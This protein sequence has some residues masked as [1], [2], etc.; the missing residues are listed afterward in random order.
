MGLCGNLRFW[1][2]NGLCLNNREYVH[3]YDELTQQ[4]ERVYGSSLHP[5]HASC[6]VWNG[7]AY[8]HCCHLNEKRIAWVREHA[9]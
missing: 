7:E 3:L 1:A 5:F 4:L 9:A 8:S 6:E 2:L